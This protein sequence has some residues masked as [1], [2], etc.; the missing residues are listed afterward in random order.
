MLNVWD[1]P[2][3]YISK[4]SLLDLHLTLH[5]M[6]DKETQRKSP[7]IQKLLN[8]KIRHDQI[9][10]EMDRHQCEHLSAMVIPAH[11]KIAKTLPGATMTR[12][13]ELQKKRK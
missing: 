2:I 9:V 8:M 10:Q 4:D 11:L 7:R 5:S 1:A 6:W 3:H 13:K 12:I